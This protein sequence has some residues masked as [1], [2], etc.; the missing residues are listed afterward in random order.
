M[1]K[2]PK[3]IQSS[4]LQICL[5][6]LKILFWAPK[7]LCQPF[8]RTISRNLWLWWKTTGDRL[9]SR[10]DCQG[11]L[12]HLWR[13]LLCY[14]RL[15]IQPRGHTDTH[16]K[17]QMWCVCVVDSGGRV[18]IW[19]LVEDENGSSPPYCPF[20]LHQWIPSSWLSSHSAWRLQRQMPVIHSLA[21]F[22]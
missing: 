4:T 8:L 21:G 11:R 15:S 16:S 17:T 22:S 12:F 7:L 10:G 1:Y 5:S 20:N 3:N 14:I 18:I 9:Q 19:L 2:L 6:L 13:S